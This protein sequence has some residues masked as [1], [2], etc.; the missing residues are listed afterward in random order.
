[1][2]AL[3]ACDYA[4][5]LSHLL[6]RNEIT[7]PLFGKHKR[8]ACAHPVA[9]RKINE[10]GRR[11]TYYAPCGKCL[12]CLQRRSNEWITRMTC[13]SSVS[14]TILFLTLTY[15]NQ[16]LEPLNKRVLQLFLKRI[17]HKVPPF[18]FVA[19]GE[20]GPR[21]SRPHYHL[22]MFF[23]TPVNQNIN[24][25]RFLINNT[26]Q[27]GRT[28]V[29]YANSGRISYVAKYVTKLFNDHET[30]TT[31]SNR[32]GIGK[33]CESYLA[34]YERFH[35]TSEVLIKTDSGTLYFPRS[36]RDYSIYS[37]PR[38]LPDANYADRT[39]LRF[40]YGDYLK[41]YE[42]YAKRKL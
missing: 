25:L 2:F 31:F 29:T 30:F 6:D 16:Y 32:P 36:W 1:M 34:L 24:E 26:W 11:V 40:Y 35:A 17:R 7:E 14:T 27:M 23:R 38:D 28:S 20:Y 10:Y 8:H 15:D 4:Q 22:V 39:S 5:K 41:A 13:E 9:I 37:A 33:D 18:R 21:T 12:Y 3:P 42:F 19:I